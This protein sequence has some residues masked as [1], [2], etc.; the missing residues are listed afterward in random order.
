MFCLV[1]RFTILQGFYEIISL[2]PNRWCLTFCLKN[3]LLYIPWVSLVSSDFSS[4]LLPVLSVNLIC[5]SYY[6][7]TLHFN[8]TGMCKELLVGGSLSCKRRKAFS[9]MLQAFKRETQPDTVAFPLYDLRDHDSASIYWKDILK[10]HV[11]NWQTNL[12]TQHLP[13]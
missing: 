9:E 8:F 2:L 10:D 12:L 1:D 11:E 13:Q 7:D 3:A 4:S 5:T 6:T